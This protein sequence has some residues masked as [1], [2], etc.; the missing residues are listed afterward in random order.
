MLSFVIIIKDTFWK[1]DCIVYDICKSRKNKSQ[2][3]GGTKEI[4]EKNSTRSL[5]LKNTLRNISRVFP[6]C[7]FFR[8]IRKGNI[9]LAGHVLYFTYIGEG[10]FAT[11]YR[12][13]LIN[14]YLLQAF[15]S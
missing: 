7:V 10:Y 3:Q 4:L 6:Q 1:Q 8:I 15:T 12:Q 14:A 11:E 13:V 2:I 9:L 5:E